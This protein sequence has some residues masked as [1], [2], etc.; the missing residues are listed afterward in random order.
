MRTDYLSDEE[1]LCRVGDDE[2]AL[3]ELYRRWGPRI[4]GVARAAGLAEADRADVLQVV[5]AELWRHARRF[6]PKRGA[7]AAWILT[8]ARRRVIDATRRRQAMPATLAM[9]DSE[10]GGDVAVEDR[11]WLAAGLA[12]LSD[13]E[14]R[15][16]QLEYWGGF[17]QADVARMWKVPLGTV[18]TWN[19]RALAKLRAV[20][21]DAS[22]HGREG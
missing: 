9:D 19:R 11:L 15:L 10:P 6:D 5:V 4:A 18:K 7:A 17:S 12:R 21:A 1:L 13:Q 3:E 22:D 2:A 14:R 8:V 16:L 20:L